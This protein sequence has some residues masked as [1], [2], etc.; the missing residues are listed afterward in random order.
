MYGHFG[1]FFA[2]LPPPYNPEHQNFEKKNKTP[3]DIKQT[4]FF[5]ILGYFCPFTTP[6]NNPE[7]QKF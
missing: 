4:E 2:L 6:P 3:G 7:N 1:P 5:V